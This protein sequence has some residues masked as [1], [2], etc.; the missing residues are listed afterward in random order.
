M[1]AAIT[2]TPELALE[3]EEAERLASALAN[4]TRHYSLPALS[5]QKMALG[6]LFW[7]A[8]RIYVPKV[9]A[10]G[11]RRQALANVTTV[12]PSHPENVTAG[13]WFNVP[14]S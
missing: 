14:G 12:A 9:Q 13:P 3:P 4:V 2:Q 11:R 1:L 8:G 7:T 6:M 10:I 5:P